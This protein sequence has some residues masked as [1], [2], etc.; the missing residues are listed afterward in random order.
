MKLQLALMSSLLLPVAASAADS[1]QPI[2][3]LAA[4]SPVANG[5]FSDAV[6][7]SSDGQTALLGESGANRVFIY[8]QSHGVWSSS[9]EIDDP[10]SSASDDF[11]IAAVLSGDG[12]TAAICDSIG[13]AYVYSDASGSWAH[14]T[15]LSDPPGLASD[16][17]CV[18]DQPI[19]ISA[20]G[21][22]LVVGADGT[23]I[24]GNAGSGAAYV[25]TETGSTWGAPVQ[26]AQPG[27][28]AGGHFGNGVAVSGDGKSVLVGGPSNVAPFAQLYQQLTGTFVPTQTFTSPN[29]GSAA[30]YGLTLALSSDGTRAVISAPFDSARGT[31]YI[32]TDD[33]GTW[34]SPVTLSDPNNTSGHFGERFA[35]SGDGNTLVISEHFAG[36]IFYSQ[37]SAG[38]W[39]SIAQVQN[40]PNDLTHNVSL[41]SDGSM[42]LVGAG[43][44]DAAGV[45]EAGEAGYYVFGAPASSGGGTGGSSSGGYGS[46]GGGGPMSPL[47]LVPL[48]WGLAQRRRKS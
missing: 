3:T 46:G 42:L 17:F 35:L 13:H 45:S 48:F 18:E 11:G 6:S 41:S 5:F 37:F 2:A 27:G 9:A 33:A 39:S 43:G 26:L 28:P 16:N 22:T 36:E 32:Y 21:K 34:S 40:L 14:V 8:V 19:S 10:G 24:A 44:A 29:P 25:Y 31:L 1:Y 47:L 20:D 30:L 23:T 4:P 15:T 38:S 7:L 12:K